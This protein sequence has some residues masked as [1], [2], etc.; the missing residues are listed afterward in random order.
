LTKDSIDL[1]KHLTGLSSEVKQYIL[2]TANYW[3]FTLTDGALR[4]LVVLYFFELGYS[5]LNIALLF[6]FYEIFGVFTN[7]VGGWIGARFG[8]NKTMNAGLFLQII[9]LSMLLVP[10]NYLSVLWVMAAQALSGIAKDLNKM[11]AKSAIK[12]LV[13]RNADKKLYHWVALLTGSKNSL[14]GAGFFLGG[15]LLSAFGFQQAILAMAIVLV[16]VWLLSIFNLKQ[17]IGRSYINLKF[18]KL[19]SKNKTINLL[20]AAR[21]FLFASRDVWFVVAL[22]IYLAETLAWSHSTVA[23]FLASWVI[24]YGVIQSIAPKLTQTKQKNIPDGKT[25]FYWVGML[26]FIPALIAIFID[27]GFPVQW[28]IIIGLIVF[29]ILFAVNSSLHSFLIVRHASAEGVSLD[30]GFYYM[31]N[32]LG[33]LF[34]TLLSGWLFQ[35]YGL[36]ACLWASSALI[37]L[38]ALITYFLPYNAIK[39]EQSMI[40]Y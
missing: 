26:F 24:I 33:R 34:G 1:L 20:S 8:L 9:A 25:A 40:H 23:G 32:A 31:A 28:V 37:G 22:P 21:L 30:I 7:L 39:N 13:P 2:I 14:K 19:F 27:Q 36:T 16:L 15:I 4:M 18:S 17:D 35:V 5:P 29:G 6:L 12:L 11:S 10:V 38:S 3:V